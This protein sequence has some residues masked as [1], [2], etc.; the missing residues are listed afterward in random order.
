MKR[1]GELDSVMVLMCYSVNDNLNGVSMK[2]LVFIL[3]SLGV[4]PLFSQTLKKQQAIE[5]IDCYF[6][7]IYAWHPNM[8]WHTPKSVVDSCM[9]EMK[10]KCYDSMPVIELR[11]LLAHSNHLFDGHTG[12]GMRQYK[13]LRG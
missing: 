5:D 10:R 8:Y 11:Y 7:T 3:F 2:W 4:G 9:E 6:Q 12:Y 13:P 1:L